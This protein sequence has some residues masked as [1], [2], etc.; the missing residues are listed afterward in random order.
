LL[1]FCGPLETYLTPYMDMIVYEMEGT[2]EQRKA[3]GQ[4]TELA[5]ADAA[6]MVVAIKVHRL[7]PNR[8]GRMQWQI[9]TI[10]KASLWGDRSPDGTLLDDLRAVFEALG[11]GVHP[12]PGSLGEWTLNHAWYAERGTPGFRVEHRPTSMC[13][14]DLQANAVGGRKQTLDPDGVWP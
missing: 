9:R 6:G 12:S 13:V 3:H 8:L 4:W 10:A 5:Y 2:R 1:L 14:A 11:S 7:W